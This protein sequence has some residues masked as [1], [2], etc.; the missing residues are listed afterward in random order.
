MEVEAFQ[1]GHVSK[2]TGPEG[3]LE[4]KGN[5]SFTCS[6]FTRGRTRP[7]G[8][9]QGHR[10]CYYKSQRKT[11]AD[12]QNQGKPVFSN[13][14]A[15][16]GPCRKTRKGRVVVSTGPF[17]LGRD[18]PVVFSK[19][20]LPRHIFRVKEKLHLLPGQLVLLGIVRAKGNMG[21]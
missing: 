1:V 17:H 14:Q 9:A 8:G 2:Q 7:G 21:A 10:C 18:A 15:S 13:V 19:A 6:P 3:T 4:G 11:F 16:G 12:F 20:I 5:A